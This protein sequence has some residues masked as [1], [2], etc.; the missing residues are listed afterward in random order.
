VPSRFRRLIPIAF[1]AIHCA[2]VFANIWENSVVIDEPYHVASGLS[3]YLERNFRADQ[4]NPPLARMISVFPLLPNP[5]A[6]DRTKISDE[7]GARSEWAIG[8]SWINLN[9]PTVIGQIRL[10][11]L[12]G[13]GWSALGAYLLYRLVARHRGQTAGTFALALWCFDPT[14]IALAAVVTADLPAAVAAIGAASAYDSLLT[15]ERLH[16]DWKRRFRAGLWLGIALLTKFTLLILPLYWLVWAMGLWFGTAREDCR[17]RPTL[18]RTIV[19]W[20]VV[21]LVAIV[22]VNAGYGFQGSCR[23]LGQNRFVSKSFAG[24]L[25]QED[26]KT[27]PGAW[28]NRFRG[29]VLGKLPIPLP[30]DFILGI[31]V[32]RRDFE[33]PLPSYVNGSWSNH[34]WWWFYIYAMALK[35]PIPWLCSLIWAVA[36]FVAVFGT[37]REDE[38]TA[39]VEGLGLTL[40]I[41]VSAQIGFSHHLRYILPA[42][43]FLLLFMSRIIVVN[44]A[45]QKAGFPVDVVKIGDRIRAVWQP[46]IRWMLTAWLAANAILST[47]NCLSYFNPVCGGSRVGHLYLLYSNVD[48]GQGL[49]Q[50]KRWIK[51]HPG[52]EP[53]HVSYSGV[54]TPE[55]FGIHTPSVPPLFL[56]R[57][58]T[59]NNQS[60]QVG[61]VSGYFAISSSLLH[62][63]YDDTYRYLL[64]IEPIDSIGGSILIYHPL[65]KRHLP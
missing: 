25:P 52:A 23:R 53:L 37:R 49:I 28:D 45:D 4:V 56:G 64:E 8:D 44:P 3:H 43:P 47:P 46:F 30:E 6:Y 12:A 1:V 35:E 36:R 10:A 39:W 11:R 7:P 9:G 26:G 38:G 51:D 24:P 17:S 50:L 58:E 60:R 63:P 13:I 57:R 55:T 42:Y 54:G 65:E 40:F 62:F 33:H 41:F 48:W 59:L 22:V 2:L 27:R 32:Q 18:G 20:L 29:T 61:P 34:G 16:V 19:A 14:V 21:G 31:D 5:P 15:A